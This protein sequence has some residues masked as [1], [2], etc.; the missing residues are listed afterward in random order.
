VRKKAEGLDDKAL[1]LLI[2]VSRK[3]LATFTG[4]GK[5]PTG[6]TSIPKTFEEAQAAIRRGE[7]WRK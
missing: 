5:S 1:D 3:K 6:E 7:L 4:K 2:E